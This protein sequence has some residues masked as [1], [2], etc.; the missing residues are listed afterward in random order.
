MNRWSMMSAAATIYENYRLPRQRG[1]RV[2]LLRH[3]LS[4][5]PDDPDAVRSWLASRPRAWAM[6]LFSGVGGLSPGLEEA[7]FSVVAAADDDVVEIETHAANIQG[8]TWVGDLS[9]T[10]DF[11]SKLEE[12]GIDDV[13]LLVGGPPCQP[14]SRAGTAKIG[15]LVRVGVRQSHDGRAEHC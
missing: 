7:G 12:W 13:D 4:P 3:P 1:E 8:L 14:F 9:G 2:T 10:N 6:D 11:L 5:D 15:H